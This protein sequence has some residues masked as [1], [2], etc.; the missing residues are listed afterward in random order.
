MILIKHLPVA[1]DTGW[2][3]VCGVP[4]L[5]CSVQNKYNYVPALQ[6][7]E[8]HTQPRPTWSKQDKH[9]QSQ[10]QKLGD[11]IVSMFGL[12]RRNTMKAPESVVS[13]PKVSVRRSNTISSVTPKIKSGMWILINWYDIQ[14]LNK[15][16]GLWPS[17]NNSPW[18]ISFKLCP[19]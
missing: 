8:L 14:F 3:G 10:S 12:K 11:K 4:G 9:Q 13:L 7:W 6:L 17:V 16:T 18:R 2:S 5:G 15:R 19:R 1:G